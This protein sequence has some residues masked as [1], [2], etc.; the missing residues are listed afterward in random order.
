LNRL[1]LERLY[2]ILKTLSINISKYLF[3]VLFLGFF[4]SVTFFNHSHI[5]NGIT[6]VHSHPYKSNSGDVPPAHNHNRNGFILIQFI[7]GFIAAVSVFF[8]INEVLRKTLNILFTIKDEP[9][10]VI[11]NLT[12]ANLPRGPTL[13]LHN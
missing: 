1:R 8:L 13:L 11:L 7:S 9:L 5:V 4:G 6:I 3:L 12:S 2:G 10:R